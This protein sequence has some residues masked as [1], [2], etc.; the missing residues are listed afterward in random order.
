MPAKP[1][2]LE[3]RIAVAQSFGFVASTHF[4]LIIDKVI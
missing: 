2:T 1:I 4:D 3:Q